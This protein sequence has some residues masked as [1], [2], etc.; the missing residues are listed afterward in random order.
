MCIAQTVILS[1]SLSGSGRGNSNINN[2]SYQQGWKEWDS[3][4]AWQGVQNNTISVSKL[5]DFM[6]NLFRYGLV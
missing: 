4:Y 1:L 6:I 2:K 5:V 3:W